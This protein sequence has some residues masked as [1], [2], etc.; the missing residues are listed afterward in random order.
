M[1]AVCLTATLSP[2]EASDLV[3]LEH[4][5]E[6][7]KKTF[8]E[9]WQALEE[10]RSRRLYRANYRTFGAYVRDR[11]HLSKGHGYR[12]CTAARLATE[13]A[14]KGLP[15]PKNER[16]A[17]L[18]LLGKQK[19]GAGIRAAP[20]WQ[21]EARKLVRQLADFHREH[22]QRVRLDALLRQY[23]CILENS[24]AVRAPALPQM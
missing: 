17:R 9:V 5:I 18:F 15:P 20:D 7:G 11:W 6:T 1:V 24:P 19:P 8:L 14:A 22:C 13:L 12:W 4:V 21:A 16:Q 23:L 2:T 3:R 10:V